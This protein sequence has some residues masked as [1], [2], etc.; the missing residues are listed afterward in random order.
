MLP[1]QVFE[2]VFRAAFLLGQGLKRANAQREE[3]EKSSEVVQK[4]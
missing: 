3:A 1:Q 4:A 2:A